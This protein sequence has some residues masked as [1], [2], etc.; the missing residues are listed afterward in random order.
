MDGV[1]AVEPAA[2][3][4]GVTLLRATWEG[5]SQNEASQDLVKQIREIEPASGEALVGGMTAETVD[6]ASSVSAHLPWMGLAVF[7]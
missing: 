2:S 7:L 3:E 1:V 4:G 5:S 6:L